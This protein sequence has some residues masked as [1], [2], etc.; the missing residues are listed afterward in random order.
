[1]GLSRR[2]FLKNTTLATS[3][4]IIG[5]YLPSTAR[6]SEDSKDTIALQPNAFI[7]IDPDNTI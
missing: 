3:A 2:T 6:A 4:F 1:M 7:Q 5:F